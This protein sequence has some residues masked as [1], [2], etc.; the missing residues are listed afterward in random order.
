MVPKK[1][2]IRGRVLE[3][4]LRENNCRPGRNNI[5]SGCIYEYTS[6]N[7]SMTIAAECLA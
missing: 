3:E 5:L 4:I 1:S 6:E 7:Q 2:D